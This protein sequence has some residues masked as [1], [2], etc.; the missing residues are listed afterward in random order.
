MS[1]YIVGAGGL[2]RE[3]LDALVARGD[4]ANAFLDDGCAGEIVRGLPVLLPGDAKGG[5]FV[6]GLA[7]PVARSRLAALLRARGLRPRTVVHPRAMVG[8][9]TTLGPGCIVLGGAHVSSSITIGA[10]CQVQ[11]NATVGHD[12]ILDDYVAVFPG[13]NISGNVRLARGVTVGSGAIVLQGR[14]VHEG[15]FVG[16][17]SVVTRDVPPGAVVTGVPARRVTGP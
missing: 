5:R 17:G 7:D 16:A 14:T 10:H 2:G 13:A 6:D 11:Y 15:A 1:L 3:V 4:V 9:E 8:P 12:A